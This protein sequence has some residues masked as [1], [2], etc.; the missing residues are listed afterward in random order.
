LKSDNKDDFKWNSLLRK[1]M[2]EGRK[3]REDEESD[4]K[5]VKNFGLDMI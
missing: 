3:A 5:R 1:R 4:R 2:R